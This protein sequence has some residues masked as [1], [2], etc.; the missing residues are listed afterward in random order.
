LKGRIDEWTATGFGNMAPWMF[1]PVL[2]SVEGLGPDWQ[3]VIEKDGHKDRVE[4]H[5]E[6]ANGLNEAR[7]KESVFESLKTHMPDAWTLYQM[8]LCKVDVKVF[9]KG[10]LREGRKL[11]RLVDRR[12]FVES[13]PNFV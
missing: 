7:I 6:S 3:I 12:I 5:V 2:G 9:A 11:S 13:S 4:L 10:S 8:G 1:E